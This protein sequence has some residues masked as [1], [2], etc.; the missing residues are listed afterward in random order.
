[1]LTDELPCSERAGIRRWFAASSCVDV[2]D[3]RPGSPAAAAAMVRV[4]M[5]SASPPPAGAVMSARTHSVLMSWFTTVETCAAVRWM[6]TARAVQPGASV[7][8]D[9]TIWPGS[10]RVKAR[11]M[12]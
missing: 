5:R 1:M 11:C 9:S 7:L 8:H 12:L 3:A 2:R 10:V 4:V 6:L